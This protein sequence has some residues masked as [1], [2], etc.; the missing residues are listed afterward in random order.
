MNNVNFQSEDQSPSCSNFYEPD[1]RPLFPPVLVASELVTTKTPP[2]GF[3]TYRK[4]L[5]RNL[6]AKG[7]KIHQARIS[8]LASFLWS[9]EPKHVQSAYN[10]LSE[11]VRKIWLERS[12]HSIHPYDP[13]KKRMKHRASKKKKSSSG[14]YKETPSVQC[15]DNDIEQDA[16]ADAAAASI[17]ENVYREINDFSSTMSD[18]VQTDGGTEEERIDEVVPYTRLKNMLRSILTTLLSQPTPYNEMTDREDFNRNPE[19]SDCVIVDNPENIKYIREDVPQVHGLMPLKKPASPI[20]QEFRVITKDDHIIELSDEPRIST[21]ALH[22]MSL[23][24]TREELLKKHEEAKKRHEFERI[25]V[26]QTSRRSEKAA[27][28]EKPFQNLRKNKAG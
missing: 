24:I 15:L 7:K 6:K 12:M 20:S 11:E 9:K 23:P 4:A 16:A 5:V 1:D 10:D 17:S 27:N 8:Q 22:P 14:I 28:V 25:N 21:N 19:S 18:A 26:G 13:E 3:L 2:N